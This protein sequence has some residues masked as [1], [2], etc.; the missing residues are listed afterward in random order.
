M[1]GYIRWN[2]VYL[3]IPP[4]CFITASV[5]RSSLPFTSTLSTPSFLRSRTSLIHH[6][7]SLHSSC[8][9]TASDGVVSSFPSDT[10]TF[11]G[12]STEEAATPFPSPSPFPFFKLRSTCPKS[13][14]GATT[15]LTLD[16]NSFVSGN[17]PSIFRSHSNVSCTTTTSFVRPDSDEIPPGSIAV[18]F[19]LAGPDAWSSVMVNVPPAE[20]TRATSP[21]VVEK[22]W[23]SSWAYFC[24]ES[25]RGKVNM[26][27]IGKL[28]VQT[29]TSW[30]ERSTYI[31]SSQIPFTLCAELDHY[32]RKL[33]C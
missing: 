24:G 16:F 26:K 29:E 27:R 21:S 6:A 19:E 25:V 2:Q 8:S 30:K 28:A 10:L 15:F 17:P 3:R 4:R 12:S 7:Q 23:R 13:L 5:S 33:N 9:P 18:V 1:E 14:P 22:V 11:D 31:S 20:G 32:A